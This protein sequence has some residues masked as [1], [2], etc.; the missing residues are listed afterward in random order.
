ME[1][2]TIQPPTEPGAYWF[3]GAAFLGQMSGDFRADA[4]I[5]RSLHF[6]EVWQVSNGLLAVTKGNFMSLNTFNKGINVPGHLG[7]WRKTILPDLPDWQIY[8]DSG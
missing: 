8:P 1:P 2:W 5:E 7:Y 3:Y 6:V 4:T